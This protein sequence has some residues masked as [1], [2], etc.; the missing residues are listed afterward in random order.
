MAF[1]L[2]AKPSR[3]Q[4]RILATLESGAGETRA[5]LGLAGSGGPAGR[6]GRQSTGRRLGPGAGP[7]GE[8]RIGAAGGDGR[9]RRREPLVAPAGGG[10]PARARDGR[11]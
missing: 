6:L 7:S 5:L 8:R 11:A 2:A 9:G 3:G 4:G 1:K 10:N